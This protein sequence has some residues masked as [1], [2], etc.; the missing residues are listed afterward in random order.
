LIRAIAGGGPVGEPEVAVGAEVIPFGLLPAL[1]P[2]L[3]SVI[4]PR[5]AAADAL[6][7]NDGRPIAIGTT[8]VT[9]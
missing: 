9:G 2:A 3:N 4:S 6:P 1:S 7:A 5:G 8:I